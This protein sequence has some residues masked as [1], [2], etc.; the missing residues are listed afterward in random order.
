MEKKRG[1]IFL[2]QDYLGYVVDL[3]NLVPLF[4]S[5]QVPQLQTFW[6]AFGQCSKL[7]PFEVLKFE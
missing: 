2:A 1:V 7:L 3:F 5:Q 6:W 4:I